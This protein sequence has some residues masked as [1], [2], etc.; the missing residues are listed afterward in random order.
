VILLAPDIYIYISE[1]ATARETERERQ[2]EG[3]KGGGRE[4]EG[5]RM[6]GERDLKR[7]TPLTVPSFFPVGKFSSQCPSILG[8]SILTI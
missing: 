8:P 5:E 4:R 7:R 2:R 1:R 3:G 6:E